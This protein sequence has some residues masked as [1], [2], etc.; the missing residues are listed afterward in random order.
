MKSEITNPKHQAS[1]NI[2]NSK[3]FSLFEFWYCLEIR[4]Y[5]NVSKRCYNLKPDR[6]DKMPERSVVKESRECF[7]DRF[8]EFSDFFEGLEL[9]VDI[10][11]YTQKEIERNDIPLAQTALKGGKIL[12]QR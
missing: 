9:G 2:K 10:F 8:I 6:E 1:S 11:V 12:F 4:I 5:G 3:P 7:I